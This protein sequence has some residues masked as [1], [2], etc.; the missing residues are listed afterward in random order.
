MLLCTV[1]QVIF[2]ISYNKDIKYVSY[3]NKVNMERVMKQ[4]FK[5]GPPHVEDQQK[6][7][8][9][10]GLTYAMWYHKEMYY[11]ICCN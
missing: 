6:C 9:A 11:R 3:E 10:V 7:V 1:Y 8:G 5:K 2:C 4:N